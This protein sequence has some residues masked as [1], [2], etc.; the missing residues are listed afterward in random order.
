MKIYAGKTSGTD[1]TDYANRDTWVRVKD[2]DSNPNHPGYYIRVLSVD[3]NGIMRYNKIPAKLLNGI[4]ISYRTWGVLA[5]EQR[6]G[7]ISDFSVVTP[8]DT[9]TT[10][11]MSDIFEGNL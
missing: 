9:L 11:E 5:N 4:S 10:D 1:L 6:T 2:N 3:S 8:I 7:H